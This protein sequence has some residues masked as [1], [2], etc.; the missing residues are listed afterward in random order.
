MDVLFEHH[1]SSIRFRYRCFDRILLNAVIQPFQQPER[2]VFGSYRAHTRSA[3]IEL[4][5]Q[6]PVILQH[7][8]T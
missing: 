3:V 7:R 5:E 6:G 2:V 4:I 1:K 8:I